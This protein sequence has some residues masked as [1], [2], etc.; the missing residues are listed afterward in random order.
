MHTWCGSWPSPQTTIT[1]AQRETR[2]GL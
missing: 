2:R 1:D